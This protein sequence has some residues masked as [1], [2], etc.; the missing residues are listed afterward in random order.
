MPIR[1]GNP[2]GI[3]ITTLKLIFGKTVTKTTEG[4]IVRRAGMKTPE[5]E[6]RA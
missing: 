4:S 6:Q 5:T 1:K 2:W 3:T